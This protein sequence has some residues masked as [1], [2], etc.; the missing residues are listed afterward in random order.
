MAGKYWNGDTNYA[1]ILQ[2]VL[3]DNEIVSLIIIV[4]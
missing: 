3:I 4:V 1:Y 2:Y